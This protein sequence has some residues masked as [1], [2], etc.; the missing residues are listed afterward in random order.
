M[1]GEVLIM[2]EGALEGEETRK[3]H[4][5]FGKEEISGLDDAIKQ[6]IEMKTIAHGFS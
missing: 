2:N 6:P 4:S 3:D 1:I 5:A